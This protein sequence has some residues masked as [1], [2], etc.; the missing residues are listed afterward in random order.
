MAFIYMQMR[1]SYK[2]NCPNSKS[3]CTSIVPIGSHFY[4]KVHTACQDRIT[5]NVQ[6]EHIL[7]PNVCDG[8]IVYGNYVIITYD[9]IPN[10]EYPI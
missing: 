7:L 5:C 3:S 1:T 8:N 6:A 2:K 9:C 4:Q 10:G